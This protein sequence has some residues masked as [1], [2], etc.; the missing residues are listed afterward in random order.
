[1]TATHNAGPYSR[2]LSATACSTVATGSHNSVSVVAAGRPS[3]TT[4]TLQRSKTFANSSS[5][6]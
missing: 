5:C 3:L 6:R 4:F 2:K 1:M